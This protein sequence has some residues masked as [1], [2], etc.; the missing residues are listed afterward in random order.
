VNASTAWGLTL[1]TLI[2][3]GVFCCAVSLNRLAESKADRDVLSW[4]DDA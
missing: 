4:R 1:L 2:A 3:V